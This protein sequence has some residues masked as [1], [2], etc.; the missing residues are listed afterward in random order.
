M[1]SDFIGG[2]ILWAHP[3][4]YFFNAQGQKLVHCFSPINQRGFTAANPSSGGFRG[5]HYPSMPHFGSKLCHILMARAFYGERPIYTDLMTGK[6]YV[7]I[8]HH[9]IN[10]KYD[11]KPVNLLCWLTKEEHREA[12]RRQRVLRKIVPNGDLHLFSYEVLALLQDPRVM[13][14]E[15]FEQTVEFNTPKWKEGKL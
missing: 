2:K 10:D 3:E 13:T 4:G 15:R 1:P 7:G 8:V 6:N 5:S 11:Y 12:D 9:L 14:K